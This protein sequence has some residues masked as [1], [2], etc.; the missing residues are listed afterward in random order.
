MTF[1]F[2]LKLMVNKASEDSKD[3]QF[4][5]C[6]VHMILLLPWSHRH[7]RKSITKTG[8]IVNIS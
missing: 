5:R 4:F 7:T 2:E 1:V 6:H 3:R 8:I